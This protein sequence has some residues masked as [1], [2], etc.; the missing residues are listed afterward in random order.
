MGRKRRARQREP[1]H[2]CP[3]YLKDSQAVKISQMTLLLKETRDN[4][5][6]GLDCNTD[7]ILAVSPKGGAHGKSDTGRR[8]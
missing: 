1:I 6:G 8:R 2:F 3:A 5:K 7:A 4:T